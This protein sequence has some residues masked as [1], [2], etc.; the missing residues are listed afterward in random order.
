M[1]F[2]QM[3]P[4]SRFGPE[5]T[6]SVLVLS[7]CRFAEAS[8]FADLLCRRFSLIKPIVC[9]RADQYDISCLTEEL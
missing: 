7:S 6:T 5:Q 8:F 2:Q 1:D 9:F 4:A 3:N